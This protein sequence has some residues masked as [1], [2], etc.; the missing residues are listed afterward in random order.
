MGISP[1]ACFPFGRG[2]QVVGWTAF[3]G[4]GADNGDV[5]GERKELGE[6]FLVSLMFCERVGESNSSLRGR[7]V[8]VFPSPPSLPLPSRFSLVLFLWLS[9]QREKGEGG[10]AKDK[11]GLSSPVSSPRG[12]PQKTH[13]SRL[14]S[15]ILTP[16]LLALLGTAKWHTTV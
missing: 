7:L 4:G 15:Q 13:P 9:A 14:S 6:L 2:Q 12:N 1:K 5:Y 11:Y 10:A 3:C 8:L 16:P